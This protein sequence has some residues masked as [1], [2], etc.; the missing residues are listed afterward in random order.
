[1]PLSEW[2]NA[3][4]ESVA[5]AVS[6]E[7]A[8]RMR[9]ALPGRIVSFDD[10]T[11]TAHV[12]PQIKQV[13]VDG[14]VQDLP[15]LQDV[16]VQFP[17]GGG[18]VLTF[19]VAEDDECLLVF[20]DRCIDGWW[21]SGEASEPMDYRLHDL[22]DAMAVVGIS[23]IPHAVQAFD[24]DA[25]ALRLLDG[26]AS[27]KLDKSGVITITGTKLHIACPVEFDQ[28]MTGKGDVVSGGISLESHPHDVKGVQPG[29]ATITSE[30]PK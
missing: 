15:V 30:K 29:S 4:L 23:S 12:Q 25:A 24:T 22:S 7:S 26:S 18:F 28:G 10:K 16:P 17:R 13:L 2:D 3:S 11:Q 6:D 9:V 21:Q 5:G 19:P 20:A 14:T 8:K 27:L 1:M